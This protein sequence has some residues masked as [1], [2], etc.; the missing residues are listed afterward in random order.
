VVLTAHEVDVADRRAR[1]ARAAGDELAAHGRLA[2]LERRAVE[3]E[4]RVDPCELAHGAVDPH[5]LADDEAE[6]STRGLEDR[7]GRAGG[8]DAELV[9][10]A[11]V[12]QVALVVARLDPPVAQHERTVRR[13]RGCRAGV[14]PTDGSERPD[15]D[16]EPAEARRVELGRE[17]GR[18]LG[19]GTLEGPA[20]RKVLDRVA[21][22]R[23]LAEDDDV[24]AGLRG[25]P[26]L[27]EDLARVAVEVPDAGVDLGEGDPGRC[28]A[29]TLVRLARP[30]RGG[31]G[32]H[33]TR[34]RDV[35]CTKPASGRMNP[36]TGSRSSCSAPWRSG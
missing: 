27:V 4:D 28:H 5:V 18:A 7:R 34:P 23:H 17:P 16:G 29:P 32:P 21:R 35:T 13:A 8:E 12:G 26:G 3:H 22:E 14:R 30:C 15:D 24:G 19:R 11:V 10:D 2:R 20:Q 36:W 31:P 6:A 9:E 1:L 25:T 33:K